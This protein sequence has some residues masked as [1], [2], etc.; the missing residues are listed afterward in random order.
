[1][2]AHRLAPNEG[3]VLYDLGSQA[4]DL[5]RLLVERDPVAI[6][7]ECSSRRWEG[8]HVQL[9]LALEGGIIVRCDLAYGART[10]ECVTIRGSK[11]T[12]TLDNPNTTIHFEHG[13]SAPISALVLGRDALV[14][15]Y[16]AI[17]RS[18]SMA[19]YSIAAAI[20]AFV[21]ALQ[22]GEPFEPGFADARRNAIWLDAAARSAR[23]SSN[24][25]GGGQR[26]ASS[27]EHG[28]VSTSRS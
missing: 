20:G 18:R 28:S 11:G 17:R 15:G 13:N 6:T 1:V 16:R 10:E 24:G 3:G 25:S 12:L 14:L 27:G 22:S 2:T 23:G 8:D 9:R 4:L 7:A 26:V 19:R 5:V 21:H